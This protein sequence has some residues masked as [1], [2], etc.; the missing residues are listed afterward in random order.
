MS[1]LGPRKSTGGSSPAVVSTMRV[2]RDGSD[3][4]APVGERHGRTLDERNVIKLVVN[5]PEGVSLDVVRPGR[6]SELRPIDGWLAG[7]GVLQQEPVRSGRQTA[8]R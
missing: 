4:V 8:P 1:E 5:E 6:P 2:V 7:D 3:I